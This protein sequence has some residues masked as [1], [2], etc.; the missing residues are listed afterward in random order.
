[1]F[2]AIWALIAG[3]AVVKESVKNSVKDFNSRY[4]SSSPF[5]TYYDHK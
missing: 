1:M 5:D 2:G 4:D 3:G